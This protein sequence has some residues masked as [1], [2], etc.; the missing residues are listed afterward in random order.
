MIFR[1]YLDLMQGLRH[2]MPF[3]AG[4]EFHD[5][6][7]QAFVGNYASSFRWWDSIMGTD[8]AFQQFR[9]KRALKKSQ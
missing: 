2:I 5:Y 7:H 9:A 3:W 4:P 1:G 6:H 8:V